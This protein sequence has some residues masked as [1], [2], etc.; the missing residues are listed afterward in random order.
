MYIKIRL[1]YLVVGVVLLLGVLWARFA[2]AGSPDSP[3]DPSTTS[4]YSLEDLYQRLNTGAAGSSDVFAEPSTA[5]GTGTM[6]TINQIMAKAPARD[7]A[8][9]ATSDDVVAGATFWG[10]TG[11]AWGPQTGERAVAPIPK[12]GQTTPDTTGDDGD[13]EMGVVWPSPR[14]IT[15]TTGIVTDTLTGLIWLQKAHC[16]QNSRDWHTALLGDMTYLNGLGTMNGHDCGDTSN[17][18]THQTDWR[19]PNVREL[20]SLVHYGYYN[21]AL[22]NTAGTGKHTVDGDPFINAQPY[23]YW[24]STTRAAKSSEAWAVDI[25]SGEV[26][27]SLKTSTYNV[28]PVRGGQ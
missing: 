10:L 28:W 15:S 19:L 6:H 7:S 1:S 4:S 3:G 18:G 21:M 27:S 17:G 12:T 9:G 16:A 5:P 8:N 25:T 11:G 20:Q 2:W 22:P 23:L 14:F 26:V 13:L 24:S